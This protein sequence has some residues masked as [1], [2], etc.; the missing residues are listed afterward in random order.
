MNTNY[1]RTRHA[2]EIM[3]THPGMKYTEALRA[4][5]A[6]HE[7][8]H[9]DA[10][11]ATHVE[12]WNGQVHQD[13]FTFLLGPLLD[14][15]STLAEI[16]IG[17]GW[18]S[19]LIAGVTDTGRNH[20]A[21]V[22]IAQAAAM[23]LISFGAQPATVHILD[24]HGTVARRWRDRPSITVSDGTRPEMI[25]GTLTSGPRVLAEHM[26]HIHDEFSR[27]RAILSELPDVPSVEALPD[28]T[29]AR[30][31][32]APMFIVV[33]DLHEHFVAQNL[34]TE[35]VIATSADSRNYI[36]ENTWLLARMGRA[37]GIH[38][39][40]TDD[41]M[42]RGHVW[43]QT[44]SNLSTRILMGKTPGALTENVIGLPMNTP[45]ADEEAQ[46]APGI[47]RVIDGNDS[48]VRLV[49]VFD[50]TDE[51]LDRILP[52]RGTAQQR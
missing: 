23:T 25:D 7:R 32:L 19:A 22:I 13:H 8:E 41:R 2:R 20:A 36:A 51:A 16:A 38:L 1:R 29:R 15:P 44:M 42:V 49:R 46:L 11:L 52:R 30:L 3:A 43:A 39:I 28:E 31:K 12:R 50:V 24:L 21:D 48:K 47:A 26:E 4:A 37:Y 45:I 27:R 35:Q 10:T 6:A 40:V 34:T 17:R 33:P 5:D 18:G 9:V 14:D